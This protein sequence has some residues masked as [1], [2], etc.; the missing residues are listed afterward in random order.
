MKKDVDIEV[1]DSDWNTPINHVLLFN[2]FDTIIYLYEAIHTKIETKDNDNSTSLSNASFK[3]NIEIV[4][5][6]VEHCY[7]QVEEK[8]ISMEFTKIDF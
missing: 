3:R 8:K 5:Y 6:L 1:K 4:K 2:H 7:S